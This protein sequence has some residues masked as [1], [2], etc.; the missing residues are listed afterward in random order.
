M[1]Q[2]GLRRLSRCW[3][4]PRG[5]RHSGTSQLKSARLVLAWW[6]HPNGGVSLGGR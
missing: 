2:Q 1:E 6:A 4:S 3:G 5:A